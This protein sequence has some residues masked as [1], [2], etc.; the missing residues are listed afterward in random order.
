MNEQVKALLDKFPEEIAALFLQLRQLILDSA[1]CEPTEALWARMPTYTAGD[2]F[3]RL[4]PFKDHINVEASAV[5][6]HRDALA[7]FKLTPKGMLQLYTGQ[8]LPRASLL[9]IFADTLSA[10][11]SQTESQ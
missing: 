11:S 4:I 2:A 8:E 6:A 5:L 3:I 10:G 7:G 1:P 9:E